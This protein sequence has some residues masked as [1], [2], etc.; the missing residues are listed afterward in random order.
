[1]FV[2]MALGSAAAAFY[3]SQHRH[4]RRQIAAELTTVNAIKAGEVAAWR[5]E[6]L[7]DGGVLTDSPFLIEAV[8]R[9]QLARQPS[10]TEQLLTRFRSV[11]SRYGYH[12]VLLVSPR[13]RIDLSPG[14][15]RGPLAGDLGV[16]FFSALRE[17]QPVLTDISSAA[18]YPFPHLSVVAP[19]FRGKGPGASAVGAVILVID[20]RQSLYPLLR[21]WP[22]QSTSLENL[23]VRRDG[24]QVVFLSPSRELPE[25]TLVN[26]PTAERSGIP[27]EQALTVTPGLVDARDVRGAQ[28]VLT[29]QPVPDS[30]WVLM[31]RMD[32]KEAFADGLQRVALILGSLLSGVAL[33]TVLALVLW[34]RREKRSYR[35][36]YEAEAARRA[37]EERYALVLRAVDDGVWDWNLQTHEVYI[38][39]RWK[40]I[41]GYAPDELPDTEASFF[42]RLHPD[43]R[44]AVDTAI[45]QHLEQGAPFRVECRLRHKDG[46]YR[47]IL[48]RAEALRDASGRPVRLVGAITD[49]TARKSA[50]L[51]SLTLNAELE[52]GVAVRT[53]ELADATAELARTEERLRYAMDATSDGLWDWHIQTQKSYCNPAYYQMLG[54]EASDFTSDLSSQWVDL[55]HPDDREVIV[56]AAQQDLV[57]EGHYQH[58]FRLRAKDGSY[59]WILRRGH[60][61]ERDASG[62]ALRAV[63][64]HIDMTE[65][66]RVE[67]ALQESERRFR[68]LAD[69]A[70][71]LIWMSGTDKL[72][73]YFNRTWLQF[74]GRPLA[75]ELGNG[76]AEGVHT[77]DCESCWDIYARAFD[78][79]QPFEMDYRLRRSDGEYRWILDTGVPR[80]D[81]SGHFLGYVG[82]C[83]DITDR[84]RA[85]AALESARVQAEAANCAK[86]AFLANMSHEIRTPM[87][88]ILGLTHLLRQD[89]P[90]PTHREKLDKIA[91]ASQHL[92]QLINDILDLA[93]I[94]EGRLV[95]E[96]AEVDLEA[97]L[98]QVS[99]LAGDKARGKGLELLLDLDSA[100]AAM[101]PLSGDSTRLAQILLNYVDNA[102]KFSEHGVIRTRVRVEDDRPESLLL[103]FE[104][105]DSGMGIAPEHLGRLFEAFEQADNS[106]TRRYGGTGLG[107]AI[108]RRLAQ[109]MGGDVGATSRPGVGSTF[110]FTARFGKLPGPPRRPLRPAE[111]RGRRALV[112]DDQAE[113]RQLLVQVLNAWDVDVTAAESGQAAL[114]TLERAAAP[115][116]LVLLDAE[117]PGLDGIETAGRMAALPL[118][119]LPMRLLLTSIDDPSLREEAMREGFA[120]VLNKPVTPSDLHDALC[121]LLARPAP[122][123][124]AESGTYASVANELFARHHGVRLLLAEDD[125]TSQD[126]SRDLL[127]YVGL[128]V[129]IANNG[130]EAVEMSRRTRYAL[131]LMDMQ[132]PEMDGPDAARA[133]RAL[134]SGRSV[135]IVAVTA[136]AFAEDRTRCLAA[137][138][139]DFMT[140]PVDPDLLYATLL[141]W[142]PPPAAS[143]PPAQ[144]DGM[145]SVFGLPSPPATAVDEASL[146]RLGEIPGVAVASGLAMLHGDTASFLD[147]LA[148]FVQSHADDMERLARFLA[149]GDRREAQ[150]LAHNLKGTAATL[151]VSALAEM[152]GELEASLVCD[153]VLPTASQPEFRSRMDAIDR[154]LVALAAALSVSDTLARDTASAVH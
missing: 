68:D 7:G 55:L 81:A 105:Q 111:L 60:V 135:P 114:D 153:D 25:S 104:V 124:T 67:A 119:E 110:W 21:S 141:K 108:N 87:N 20:V 35:V 80:H 84:K 13:G 120:A 72:C 74:T 18:P 143:E 36:L 9:W 19:L 152:A 71:V 83:I 96:E 6:R 94:E 42:D 5:T 132:M 150:R 33:L 140:K 146:V 32:R 134:P 51:A 127:G 22:T 98:W 30:P 58:E 79:R 38:A 41:V 82:S 144:P 97:V 137:G 65:R 125:P 27:L 39:P 24:E 123:G 148:A 151:G 112:V 3:S 47:W 61:V 99:T 142:L 145:A 69:S 43:D 86:S 113:A 133:I 136:N 138:M 34:Q 129:D 149:A 29:A 107:L 17:R 37:S 118:R 101:P 57:S 154:L 56:A 126:V 88:A 59:R 10:L 45:R 16:A 122:V 92:L 102:V 4:L 50:E 89:D 54:Y 52:R 11:Q 106:T 28:V 15:N 130:V 109:L 121:G 63:G 128:E 103:R 64:T 91:G 90:D 14:S 78:A 93:K 40:E 117:M 23:L 73:T 48:S 44:T 76:W 31:T 147:M 85:A 66:K 62:A 46:S 1:V 77:E 12:D 70:P 100:L 116:D 131:I 75:R 53:A 115:Y 139:N 49:I 8:R 26:Q 2:I 95:L